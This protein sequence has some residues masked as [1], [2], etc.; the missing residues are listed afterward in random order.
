MNLRRQFFLLALA[1]CLIG[2]AQSKAI[3]QDA[4]Q[5]YKLKA[6]TSNQ[7]RLSRS[8]VDSSALGALAPKQAPPPQMA[9]AAVTQDLL[10][11]RF[12]LIILTL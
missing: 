1:S 3:A 6:M 12:L 5:L 2:Y 7:S 9:F 11:P 10:C 8:E 4:N